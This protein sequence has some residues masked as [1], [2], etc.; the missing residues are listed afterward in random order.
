MALARARMEATGQWHPRQS[1][2]RRWAI[3]CVALE[4]TQRCNLDCTLCYLSDHSEAVKE[5][6][7][8]PGVARGRSG[9]IDEALDVTTGLLIQARDGSASRPHLA[10]A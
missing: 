4:I 7:L 3:G 1:M 2:G 8:I 6:L 10:L 5:Y 9:G